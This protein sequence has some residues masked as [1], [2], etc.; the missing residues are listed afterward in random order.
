[1][2]QGG[3]Q[4]HGGGGAATQPTGR[5]VC[6]KKKCQKKLKS[7]PKQTFFHLLFGLNFTVETARIVFDIPS[8]RTST[9]NQHEIGMISPRPPPS[10]FQL[11][12][13]PLR[14]TPLAASLSHDPAASPATASTSCGVGSPPASSAPPTRRSRASLVSEDPQTAAQT[15]VVVSTFMFR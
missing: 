12:A 10:A 4:G 5:P 14:L 15:L 1:M 11:A 6:L 13:G 2:V 7:K 9:F 3:G 8:F